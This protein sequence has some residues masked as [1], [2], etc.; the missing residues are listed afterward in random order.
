M[1][2]ISKYFLFIFV[3]FVIFLIVNSL[4]KFNEDQRQLREEQIQSK[5]KTTSKEGIQQQNPNTDL[6]RI[7]Q[8][9]RRQKR[10]A[11]PDFHHYYYYTILK[12]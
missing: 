4:R 12:W 11:D 7:V 1:K 8:V 6:P 5:E 3:I 9:L 2:N 10:N